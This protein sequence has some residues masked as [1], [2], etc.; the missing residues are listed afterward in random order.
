MPELSQTQHNTSIGISDPLSP[1]RRQWL[2]RSESREVAAAVSARADLQPPCRA[3]EDARAKI[4]R[5]GEKAIAD[6]HSQQG[7]G[8]A[9]LLSSS[10]GVPHIKSQVVVAVGRAAVVGQAALIAERRA[11]GEERGELSVEGYEQQRGGEQACA[12]CGSVEVLFH[13]FSFDLSV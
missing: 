5:D 11:L 3:G 12:G 13:K 9:D 4:Q 8:R 2:S 1:F 6:R 10:R 7:A